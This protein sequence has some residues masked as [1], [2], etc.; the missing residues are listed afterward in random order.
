[1]YIF[2]S[3]LLTGLRDD[4]IAYGKHRRLVK[5][6]GDQIQVFQ[7]S[8]TRPPR[9]FWAK[10]RN[11]PSPTRFGSGIRTAKQS[12][13]ATATTASY[14]LRLVCS[15]TSWKAYKV[16]FPTDPASYPYQDWVK[17]SHCFIVKSRDLFLP[18]VL[19][20]CILGRW[21]MYQVGYVRDAS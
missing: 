16:Y 4:L 6:I 13:L 10:E 15:S 7:T 11:S 18:P 14:G 8:S 9:H 2:I 19:C 1:V 5:L 21:P 17:S 3:E 20:H 12:Y